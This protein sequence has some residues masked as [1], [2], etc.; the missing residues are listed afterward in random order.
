MPSAQL[1]LIS[2]SFFFLFSFEGAQ[3][4]GG[5]ENP[6]KFLYFKSASEL[7]Y[8][9]VVKSHHYS[10]L[11]D[12]LLFREVGAPVY[13]QLHGAVKN[14]CAPGTTATR[15][16]QLFG[17]FG[18]A[19]RAERAMLR[20]PYLKT[21]A[22][23]ETKPLRWADLL[24]LTNDQ[25]GRAAP[26]LRSAFRMYNHDQEEFQT[27]YLLMRLPFGSVG[28]ESLNEVVKER[29]EILRAARICPNST[30]EVLG[31]QL[32]KLEHDRFLVFDPQSP[33]RTAF[34]FDELNT[35]V[36]L[37]YS[38]LDGRE[39][40]GDK[41]QQ[42][43]LNKEARETGPLAWTNR[44]YNYEW[45]PRGDSLS[46]V[47]VP[48]RPHW[49]T[50]LETA[51]GE[52]TPLAITRPNGGSPERVILQF[53]EVLARK[54]GVRGNAVFKH[55]L[56]ALPFNDSTATSQDRDTR[57]EDVFAGM[58]PQEG[59]DL[60]ALETD[61]I[62]FEAIL[63]TAL[64]AGYKP[65]STAGTRSSLR[66]IDDLAEITFRAQSP[67]VAFGDDAPYT[68]RLDGSKVNVFDYAISHC[69]L[70]DHFAADEDFVTNGPTRAFDWITHATQ[71][72]MGKVDV[73]R[74]PPRKILISDGESTTEV[75]LPSAFW[76]TLPG[77]D[78]RH[79]GF[80]GGSTVR[81]PVRFVLVDDE[82]GAPY[83]LQDYSVSTLTALAYFNDDRIGYNRLVTDL[84][85]GQSNSGKCYDVFFDLEFFAPRI[86]DIDR[87]ED[88]IDYTIEHNADHNHLW[89]MSMHNLSAELAAQDA[90][91][92]GFLQNATDKTCHRNKVLALRNARGPNILDD[93]KLKP[94]LSAGFTANEVPE[95]IYKAIMDGTDQSSESFKAQ[96]EQQ[97]LLLPVL[98]TYADRIVRG[99]ETPLMLVSNAQALRL[100]HR[101]LDLPTD[102]DTGALIF[103]VSFQGLDWRLQ[104]MTARAYKTL[105][106]VRLEIYGRDHTRLNQTSAAEVEA[107]ILHFGERGSTY[108]LPHRPHSNLPHTDR[109][110]F[111]LHSLFD[112]P[113]IPHADGTGKETYARKPSFVESARANLLFSAF[114]ARMMLV[115][116][117]EE[118]E[119]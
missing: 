74:E 47:L 81:Q 66:C 37:F 96:F 21:P 112:G 60:E 69:H 1:T 109:I 108:A 7:D 111:G 22:R 14:Q 89:I 28:G 70:L 117:T 24:D 42:V 101:T 84:L 87:V 27:N 55:D 30:I 103:H 105:E 29:F 53:P 102:P 100:V 94:S 82:N 88:D 46:S 90:T 76:S 67:F 40:R 45:G 31:E 61:P 75:N 114:S 98:E 64:D 17:G 118:P 15:R 91:N 78:I 9:P 83:Y 33:A 113:Y 73:S 56:I 65:D 77:R 13:A 36:Q 51:R 104:P 85:D 115:L 63:N 59:I 50:V 5:P 43:P 95:D 71:P 68:L 57:I 41:A 32:A 93:I 119:E 72:E 97:T 99:R 106:E 86:G 3:A 34:L 12:A 116:D 4:Q 38:D 107:K 10:T 92:W 49:K 19:C 39:D 110:G 52:R 44:L 2:V 8:L 79:P 80:G 25:E 62:T 11:C 48:I 54:T 26:R 6:A 16:V 23:S 20:D 18:E 35:P 58:I